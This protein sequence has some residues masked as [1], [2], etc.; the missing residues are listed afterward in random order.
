MG[1]EEGRAG[2]APGPGEGGS[3]A[4]LES[5]QRGRRWTTEAGFPSSALLSKAGT[6][7]LSRSSGPSSCRGIQASVFNPRD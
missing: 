5:A 1:A 2:E 3:Q 7:S 6:V 4:G